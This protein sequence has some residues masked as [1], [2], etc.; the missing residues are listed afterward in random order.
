MI[1]NMGLTHLGSEAFV[2]FSISTAFLLQEFLITCSNSAVTMTNYIIE[3]KIY[4][5]ETN[6]P[7]LLR[8]SK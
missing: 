2:S 1:S 6:I 5:W 4:Q 8:M 7:K 3:L